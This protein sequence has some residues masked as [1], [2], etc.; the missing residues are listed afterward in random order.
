MKNFYSLLFLCLSASLLNAQQPFTRVYTV[1]NTKCQN[2]SCHSSTAIDGS[3]ALRFT[4][5]E[6]AVWNAIYNVAPANASSLAKHEKLVKS[7]HPYSSF[8][9][10]KI[11]GASFDT[12]L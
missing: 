8:L 12:D 7:Q 3:Q 5:T 9:L 11:A 6:T 10:R 4:G 2:S 1:L